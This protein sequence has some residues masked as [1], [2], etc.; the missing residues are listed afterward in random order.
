VPTTTSERFLREFARP[1]EAVR[2]GGE[3]DPEESKVVEALARELELD[4]ERAARSQLNELDR[5][6]ADARAL[7]DEAQHVS[8]DSYY[9]LRIGLLER[10]PLL[11]HAWEPRTRQLI[12]REGTRILQMLSDSE[13]ARNYAAA[14]RELEEAQVQH[15][16]VR[17][18]RARTMRLVR[19]HETL[20]LA[21]VLKRKS[22]PRYEHY[23]ALRQCERYVPEVRAPLRRAEQRRK[24]RIS[25]AVEAEAHAK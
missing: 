13:L 18:S 8:D 4:D 15:D 21:S 19:A 25:P 10:W 5:I 6:L 9:A 23:K 17:V 2:G 12:A 3:S 7:L 11:E 20:R 22:G 14:E 24:A 16:A 1:H